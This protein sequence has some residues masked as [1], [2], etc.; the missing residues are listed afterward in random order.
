QMTD[1]KS[2]FRNA[3]GADWE[4]ELQ[5]ILK[6]NSDLKCNA[7]GNKG[8]SYR[9]S[10][11]EFLEEIDYFVAN[12]DIRHSNK[13]KKLFQWAKGRRV[14]GKLIKNFQNLPIA[15]ELSQHLTYI[16][17]QRFT[18][19]D[20]VD[21]GKS[22]GRTKKRTDITMANPPPLYRE[23]KSLKEGSD[24][25]DDLAGDV[26]SGLNK[27]P[28]KY[29]KQFVDQFINGYL[30]EI[31]SLK[32]LEYIFE[33]RKL[34]SNGAKFIKKQFKGLFLAKKEEIFEIIWNNE[35]LRGDLLKTQD[36]LVGLQ[37]FQGLVLDDKSKLYS[38][39]KAQ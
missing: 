11:D 20:I 9:S 33:A 17:K 7:C 21:F 23:L 29:R 25:L 34:G 6:N 10:M 24:G 13:G 15:D 8:R 22:I 27:N 31:G 38:F 16:K 36:E 12:F 32:D 35:S 37:R 1:V 2:N 18:G 26:M 28:L 19:A 39:I 14:D 4:K 3:L 5:A 30:K